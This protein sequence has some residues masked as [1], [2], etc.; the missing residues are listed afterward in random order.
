[1]TRLEEQSRVVN[2][3]EQLLAKLERHL[4]LAKAYGE[5]DFASRVVLTSSQHEYN[6]LQ[7]RLENARSV[8]HVIEQHDDLHLFLSSERN[9]HGPV[10]IAQLG[11]FL[12]HFQSLTNSLQQSYMGIATS[13]GRVQDQVQMDACLY[14]YGSMAGSYGIRLRTPPP[15]NTALATGTRAAELTDKLTEFLDSGIFDRDG[16]IELCR[17]S[18]RTFSAYRE[19]LSHISKSKITVK[20]AS[21]NKV[22]ATR[23]SSDQ[24]SM[25]EEALLSIEVTENEL[26]VTGRLVGASLNRD[27]F[28]LATGDTTYRGRTRTGI[29]DRIATENLYGKTVICKLLEVI[30]QQSEGLA[31]PI[32]RYELVDLRVRDERQQGL[33]AE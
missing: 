33:F 15:E 21:Y 8:L 9:P 24:A 30:E 10:P 25:R 22:F 32:V 2:R 3:L 18:S 13:R 11:K 4:E 19:L 1:M 20:I 28:E 31:E 29:A 26:E 6:E 17:T 27:S 14:A 16:V 7:L 5:Q 12:H 23:M